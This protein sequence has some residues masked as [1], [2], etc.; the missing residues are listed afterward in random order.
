MA[1][2]DLDIYFYL[3]LGTAAGLYVLITN[4]VYQVSSRHVH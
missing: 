1:R 3:L 4:F 2:S